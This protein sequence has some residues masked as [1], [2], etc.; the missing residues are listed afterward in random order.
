MNNDKLLVGANGNS[1]LVI[2]LSLKRI[3]YLFVSVQRHWLVPIIEN[4][5]IHIIIEK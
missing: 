2:K 5:K 4:I 3:T 1:P